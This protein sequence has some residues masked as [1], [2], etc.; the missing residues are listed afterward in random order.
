MKEIGR[1]QKLQQIQ[2]VEAYGPA[3]FVRVLGWDRL[4]M[5]V[6]VAKVR[7]ELKDRSLH[8]YIPVHIVYGQK[9]GMVGNDS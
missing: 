7:N 4:E 1:F 3:L 9:P 5:E 6:L 8:L 2:A